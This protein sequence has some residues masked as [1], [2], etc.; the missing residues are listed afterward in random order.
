MCGIAGI[1]DT[2]ARRELDRQLLRSMRD[3]LRHRG[4][5][6]G[7]ELF[8]P[9]IALGHRRLSIIDLS[10][11]HQPLFNEDDSVAVVFNGEIYNF[12]ELSEELQA[13][14]HRFRTVSDT[15]V[16]VHAWEQWGER[17]VERFNGMFAFAVWD[18]NQECLFLARDRLGKKPLY[19]THTADGLLLFA[20]ELKG[21]LQHGA[22]PREFDP[23]AIEQYFALGYVPDPQCIIRGVSKLSAAHTL[24]WRRGSARA[25][26][27]RRYWRPVFESGSRAD[28]AAI[29]EE[30]IAR[31]RRAVQLRLMS[32]VPLGAFLSGGIDSS[33]VVAMM[34]ETAPKAVVT[35][36]IGFEDSR[37]DESRYAQMVADRFRT[38]HVTRIVA[39]DDFDLLDRLA[40]A[41]DE[42]FADSSAIPTYRVCQ[43]ARERVT[44]AL[45]G[46]GG[47]E[48]FAGYRRYRWHCLE[49]RMRRRVPEAI[50]G[51]LFGALGRIYPKMD[52][53]PKF[54]RAKSTLE[55][56]ARSSLEGYFHGVGIIP[57]R[58]RLRL[59]S[60][61]L[62]KALDGYHA[63]EVFERHAADAARLDALSLVQ[64]VDFMTYLPGDILV[65]VDRASMAHSL[66]VRAPLLDYN[67][68]DWAA[69]LDPGLKL[70]GTEGKWILKKSLEG[71]LPQEVLYRSKMGFAVPI[72]EW[73]RGPLRKRVRQM[74]LG[75]QLA[76]TG[77]FDR[78]ML[79]R[80][81]REHEAGVGEHSAA[82]W[83]LLM[84]AGSLRHLT[85]TSDSAASESDAAR[86]A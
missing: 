67:L 48:V 12:R 82:L 46:D 2:S 25:P 14:G 30:L 47:D 63:I 70:H 39:N 59:Y 54:L 35:C 15:E 36:S 73:F 81:V 71:H 75:Q 83:A 64:Y 20:S 86:Y 61:G 29:Q 17:C 37:Y 85:G 21:L 65:K 49:E 74:V 72:A 51:P 41:Y 79:E 9:G 19:Y 5:D 10:G 31:L 60:P 4:P 22:V 78:G 34:A 23:R 6:D 68:V 50:R 52:W 53:A 76:D 69:T 62:R 40:Q 42:P 45:S 26:E 13:S 66:E 43:V 57:D 56:I 38:N 27:P 16:I 44:V 58:L 84:F 33:A 3:A 77:W 24:L 11:G 7:G 32:E 28:A 1:F 18:R 80:L 55:S 8:G